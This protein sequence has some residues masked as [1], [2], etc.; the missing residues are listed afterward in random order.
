MYKYVIQSTGNLT[1]DSEKHN[2][3]WLYVKC[4]VCMG[5]Y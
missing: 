3:T 2:A 4:C 5:V 1:S